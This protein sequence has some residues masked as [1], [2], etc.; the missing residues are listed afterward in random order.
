MCNGK[1]QHFRI[2]RSD[3]DAL[4]IIIVYNLCDSANRFQFITIFNGLISGV[5]KGS[6]YML[7]LLAVILLVH[8]E[9]VIVRC[10]TVKLNHMTI[11]E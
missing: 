8:I 11:F 6:E 1:T 5:I 10:I 9:L 4:L 7:N 2:E 3:A